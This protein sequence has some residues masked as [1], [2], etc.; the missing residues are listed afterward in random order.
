MKI[1]KDEGKIIFVSPRE[2]ISHEKVN[3]G[4][5]LFVLLKMVLSGQFKVPLLIDS[6]TKTILDGH[7]RCYASHRLGLKKVPCYCVDYLKDQ[8]IEVH[9]RKSEI[10][11]D[12]KGVI[13]MALSEKVFPQKTTRHIYKIPSFK[14]SILKELWK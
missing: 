8:S 13:A 4:H 5:A 10:P 2:L 7:H 6:K 1:E 11:I 14:P 3:I 12:K 9:P